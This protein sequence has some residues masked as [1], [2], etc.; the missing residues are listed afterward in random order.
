M[1][2]SA[3]K[4]G[5]PKKPGQT[6]AV[7]DGRV[8]DPVGPLGSPGLD[9]ENLKGS[10]EDDKLD[11]VGFRGGMDVKLDRIDK[12]TG[13][14]LEGEISRHVRDELTTEVQNHE[15]LCRQI[16]KWNRQYHGRKKAKSKPWSG[17]SNVSDSLT[18]YGV[19]TI[20]VRLLDAIFNRRKV[21]I[22][23][24]LVSELNDVARKL[25]DA[26]DWF[27]KHVLRL[28]SKLLS[29]I[30]QQLKVGT[31]IVH[32][33]WESKKRVIYRYATEDEV[34]DRRVTKY[35]VAGT[36][37]KLV[38]D[39]QTV[40]EGPQ[41]FGLPRED[42]ISSSDA[43]DIPSAYISGFRKTYRKY[44]L[45][46]KFRTGWRKEVAGKI[47]CPDAFPETKEDKVDLQDKDL[48]KTPFSEP[49]T[50]W[51]LWLKF[52][53][54]GDGSPDDLTLGYHLPSEQIVYCKYN[55]VFTGNRPFV[56]IVGYPKEYSFDG[57]GVCEAI[58]Q[59]QEQLDTIKNQRFDRMTLLNNVNTITRQGSGLE[60]FKMEMGKNWV[61]DDLDL[62]G[63]F[64]VIPVPD[65]FP[66]TYQEEASTRASWE[67]AIGITPAVMGIQT[68]E[69]PVA[70]VELANIEE[71]NKKFKSYID[72]I[73][74][75]I[76]EIFYQILE[77]WAQY[78]PT[79]SYRLEEGGGWAEHTVDIPNVAAIREGLELEL[80]ASTEM[81][82]QESRRE[83]NIVI[84]QMLTDYYTRMGTMAQ[85]VTSPMVP[86]QFKKYAFAVDR[87][88]AK[89]LRD[90]IRDFDKN[91]AE[92][93]VV[94]LSDVINEQ[95]VMMPPPPPMPPVEGGPPGGMPGMEGMP[96]EGMGGPAPPQGMPMPPVPMGM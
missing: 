65:I 48:I 21:I 22:V 75:A 77:L 60:N 85:A 62:E 27:Q 10:P 35:P 87:A 83:V 64:K 39:I 45:E 61:C 14:S 41:V 20:L 73:R 66:S 94:G 5:K 9:P 53:V 78:K 37:A 43:D 34:D 58:Y 13:R 70:K 36:T 71:A 54:D 67:K 29:P 63:A 86:P 57:M 28:R 82:S 79:V 90:I 92:E 96:G 25:E 84:Y 7:V 8:S 18:R 24:S 4:Q 17:A 52:D 69:R 56:K 59:D 15:R 49:Y 74:E 3:G 80:A 47:L 51:H 44:E 91:N 16:V 23:R 33:T 72:N 50:I 42:Y 2:K 76:Q 6:R 89:V 81:I 1:A 88:G 31:G 30:I 11:D 12:E 95:E 26:L 55:P 40:Y 19:D 32:V 93:L 68:A 46:H 38:K